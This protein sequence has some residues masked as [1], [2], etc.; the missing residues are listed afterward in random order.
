MKKYK[1][2]SERKKERDSLINRGNF[3]M[4]NSD[5][6]AVI[7]F[8][9]I[10]VFP[11]SLIGYYIYQYIDLTKNEINEFNDGISFSGFFE[12]SAY[13]Y[14]L[15]IIATIFYAFVLKKG[16]KDGILSKLG[17]GW[18]YTQII[19]FFGILLSFFM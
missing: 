5:W 9:A 11:P 13:Y 10:G 1:S 18:Y 12:I 4:D 8:L 2:A 14:L 17:A 16:S 19:P 7:G 6:L 3:Q 15:S